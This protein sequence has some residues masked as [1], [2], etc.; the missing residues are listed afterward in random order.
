MVQVMVQSHPANEMWNRN[1]MM[2][3]IKLVFLNSVSFCEIYRDFSAS[4]GSYT[5]YIL[6][7]LLVLL[8]T[9]LSLK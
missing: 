6:L 3:V 9:S 4:F 7:E 8:K 1:L 2:S 5:K